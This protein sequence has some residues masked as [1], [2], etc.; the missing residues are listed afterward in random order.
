MLPASFLQ[1][2]PFDF[3]IQGS[4]RYKFCG[5]SDY[6]RRLVL[7]FIISDLMGAEAIFEPCHEKTCFTNMRKQKGRSAEP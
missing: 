7:D 1:S 2:I 4:D 6:S 3:F 5:T